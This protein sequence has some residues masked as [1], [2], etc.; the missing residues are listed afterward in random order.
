MLSVATLS[1][2]PIFVMEHISLGGRGEAPLGPTAADVAVGV[3][4]GLATTILLGHLRA[5]LAQ[6]M[7]PYI[8]VCSCFC[9]ACCTVIQCTVGI[10]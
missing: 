6:A 3:L 9:A 7:R 10:K 4:F 1:T 8:W 2:L 5:M